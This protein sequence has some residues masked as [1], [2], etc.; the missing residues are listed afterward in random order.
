MRVTLGRALSLQTSRLYSH[1]P[2]SSSR[3]Q[4]SRSSKRC[5]IWHPSIRRASLIG[6]SQ[7][8]RRQSLARSALISRLRPMRGSWS[9]RSRSH[10]KERHSKLKN[11][12]IGQ[13]RFS[14]YT[15]KPC[16]RKAPVLAPDITYKSRKN[17][18]IHSWARAQAV[19]SQKKYECPPLLVIDRQRISITVGRASL[20]HSTRKTR[21]CKVSN[22]PSHYLR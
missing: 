7:W 17:C 19:R 12:S 22:F 9:R 21:S 3:S 1:R 8:G 11:T 15:R 6:S 20:A 4:T 14:S 13:K 10:G 5:G 16:P 2:R 18:I